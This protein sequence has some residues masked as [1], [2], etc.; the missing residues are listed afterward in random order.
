MIAK[1]FLIYF[2]S[3]IIFSIHIILA[4]RYISRTKIKALFK[5]LTEEVFKGSFT[6]TFF[7]MIGLSA[8]SIPLFLFGLTKE[9]FR[10]DILNTF[11]NFRKTKIEVKQAKERLKSIKEIRKYRE[12][13]PS[14][15][16]IIAKLNREVSNGR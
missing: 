7:V 3:N 6:I 11:D 8:I 15:E 13:N 9:K 4:A 16:D 12:E 5:Q 10:D 2:L 14:F 1:I